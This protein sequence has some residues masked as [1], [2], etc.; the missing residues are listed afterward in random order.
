MDVNS[1][2]NQIQSLTHTHPYIALAVILFLLSMLSKNKLMDYLL[3]FLAA[4][5][6]LKGFGLTDTFFSFIKSIPS[7]IKDIISAFGGA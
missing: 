5:A 4:L 2:I 3:W 7:T 1:V 6:L